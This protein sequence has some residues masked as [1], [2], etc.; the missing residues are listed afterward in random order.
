MNMTAR[1]NIYLTSL[2][3]T[4]V[5]LGV[6]IS[7]LTNIYGNYE[8]CMILFIIKDSLALY[9]CCNFDIQTLARK[10]M[11]YIYGIAIAINITLF[12]FAEL[13]AETPYIITFAIL[14][15]L[16]LLYINCM[17]DNRDVYIDYVKSVIKI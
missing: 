4:D 8:I 9:I 7:N 5:T 3:I 16:Q 1:P 12:I 11:A 15:F 17:W 10:G 14:A 2:L 13:Y 6:G